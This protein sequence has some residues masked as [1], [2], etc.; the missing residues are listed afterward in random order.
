L[1]GHAPACWCVVVDVIARTWRGWTR[2]QDADRYFEY[3]NATGVQALSSTPGNLGV[4][5]LRRVVDDRAEVV[6][7]SLWESLEHVRAFA[8]EDV[9]RAVFYPE[10]EAYLVERDWTVAH[11]DVPIAP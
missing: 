5:V 10:D 9:G 6:V 3:V 2:A 7:I 11:Y 1:P 4:Y 8:G